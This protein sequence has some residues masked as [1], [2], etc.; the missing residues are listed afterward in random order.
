MA[1]PI[2]GVG[3]L[4]QGAEH[5]AV[6]HVVAVDQGVALGP[7]GG[8]EE[9]AAGGVAAVEGP[10]EVVVPVV[11]GVHHRVVHRG[12]RDGEPPRQVGVLVVEGRKLGEDA[13]V[14]LSRGLPGGLRRGGVAGGSPGGLRRGLLGLYGV[15][16]VGQGLVGVVLPG[17][18]EGVPGE[19]P[20]GDHEDQG[21]DQDQDDAQ[22]LVHRDRPFFCG[23]PGRPGEK[24][25]NCS[26]NRPTGGHFPFL[27]R[28]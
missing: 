20:P 21:Q 7:G 15:D 25:A 2:G 13:A 22:G 12:A 10:A 11:W 27:N 26:G 23:R 1:L 16:L 17:G 19:H 9:G 24:S 8:D 4:R 5:G 18:P 6:L 14:R 28:P 3:I